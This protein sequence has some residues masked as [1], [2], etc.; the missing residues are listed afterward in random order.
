M[1]TDK[2]ATL[3]ALTLALQRAVQFNR[4]LPAYTESTLALLQFG[5]QAH[6]RRAFQCHGHSHTR[7]RAY[8]QRCSARRWRGTLR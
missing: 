6:R 8:G 4:S 2:Q 1:M 3:T 7:S 5:A